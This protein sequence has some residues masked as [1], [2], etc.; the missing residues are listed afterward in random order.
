MRFGSAKYKARK[1]L[2]NI[3]LKL[4]KGKIESIRIEGDFFFYPEDKLWD[5][6][7]ALLGC[8]I[9]IGKITRRIAEFYKSN[10]ISSPGVEPEDF[11]KAITLAARSVEP[12]T[13]VD[14][15]LLKQG[16]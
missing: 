16:V 14:S 3:K 11:A 10:G 8:D 5:L 15:S 1:G 9:E 6:E 4:D 7:K 12:S 2:I 13:I